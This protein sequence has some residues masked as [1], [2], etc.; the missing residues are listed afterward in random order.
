LRRIAM[1]LGRCGHALAH[2][3]RATEATQVLARSQAIYDETGMS[4]VPWTVPDVEHTIEVIREK[5]DDT[6]YDEAWKQG[7][8]LT[9][10]EAVELALTVNDE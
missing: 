1:L 4:I 9:V 7:A 5:L 3:E 6:A 10:D 2:L 8:R